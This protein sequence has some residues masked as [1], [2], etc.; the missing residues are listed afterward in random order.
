VDNVIVSD[1]LEAQIT[2]F[3]IGRILDVKGFTTYSPRNIRF[4][5]PELMP[6]HESGVSNVRPTFQSDIFSLGILLL[7]IFHGP[8]PQPQRGLPYNHVR[9]VPYYDVSLVMR[10]HSGDR[11]IRERYNWIEDQHWQLLCRCWAGNPDGRPAI[12]RVQRDL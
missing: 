4:T 12:D 7:Q 8:D 11:P 1:R 3:G 5:A 9:F 10:I 2:D 6:A